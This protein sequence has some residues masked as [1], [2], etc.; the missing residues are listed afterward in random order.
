MLLT[1]EEIFEEFA[2]L[3]RQDQSLYLLELGDGLPELPD[4]ARTDEN[5]VHGCQS[6]VWLITDVEGADETARFNIVADSDSNIVR[7]LI[8]IL[9]ASY[10]GKTA[11]EILEYDIDAVF[12]RLNLQQH[13]TPQRRNGLRG[14]V[15]RVLKLA[16]M[17]LV[18]SGSGEPD[19]AS[20][21]NGKACSVRELTPRLDPQD[22]DVLNADDIRRQFPV[23]CQTLPSGSRPIFLDSG[24]SAQKPQCVIDKE[25]EVEEQYFANAHRG[26]YQF[27]Q[28]I[29]E[30]F[31]GAR[32]T[33]AKFLNAP[34][35]NTIIFT[36]GTTIG[37][38]MIASGW[39]R[40]HVQPGDEILTSVM[41]HH[42]NFVPWQQLAKERGAT[43]KLIPLTPDG[44][45]D[46]DQL[47]SVLT[48]R[49]RLL[50][51]TGMSNMLGTIN[52]I[53]ELVRRARAVGACVVVDGAQSVP[54]LPT[55]VIAEDVDFL[56]FSGHK[57]Y[58]PTGVG[59]LYGKPERLEEMDP[60]IFGGHM[61]SEVRIE[62]SS[63]S[64]APAKFEA[65]TMPIV[66]AIALGTA[67]QWVQRTGLESMHQHEQ[68]LTK[69]TME[70]LQTV[71]GIT[72]YGPD[73]AHRGGIITFRIDGMHPEDLAAILDQQDVFARHGHHCT[74]PLH[75][76]LG[77]S[78]TTRVSLAA[79]NTVDDITALMNAIEFAFKKLVMR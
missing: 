26:T 6:Q 28:R 43:L 51:I 73:A 7:G 31:E 62:E 3:D 35:A 69:E 75:A 27:G 9:E 19:S 59:I 57:L 65:G 55:D 67:T 32:S 42:A 34:S 14:M 58:G 8:A 49:T 12:Q 79:Y 38:N 48:K 22:I 18:K 37:L 16:R 25:R 54:H 5:K 52:P 61:I 71:P 13:I 21:M 47:D 23:L 11:R 63:W 24:A 70:R 41:E 56:A 17:H 1:L 15:D 66:Q 10:N 60:I 40:R 20:P 2:D 39:G 29:D 64:A 45:L 36:P 72:I 46:M 77:V 33:I 74:M 76:H 68:A 44:R 50:A 30:E 78:A 53:R 4:D